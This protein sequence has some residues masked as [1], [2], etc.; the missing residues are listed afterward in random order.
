M[1]ITSDAVWAGNE[2]LDLV[3]PKGAISEEPAKRDTINS[4]HWDS[5]RHSDPECEPAPDPIPEVGAQEPYPS[6]PHALWDDGGIVSSD[7]ESSTSSDGRYRSM[8]C[9]RR[10][11]NDID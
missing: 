11:A 8:H 10:Q 9:I 5:E 4:S 3:D 6:R 7:S 1:P 2:V